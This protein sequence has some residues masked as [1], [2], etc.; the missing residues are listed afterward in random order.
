MES[1]TKKQLLEAIDELHRQ[2]DELRDEKE[3]FETWKKKELSKWER[4]RLINE[5]TSDLIAIT[6]FSLNPVYTYLSPSHKKVLGYEPEELMGKP[7]IDYIHPE[8]KKRLLL[9]R[10]SLI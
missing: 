3:Q 5:N 6:T 8:D 2:V 7:G 1:H 9:C 10:S 4:Y